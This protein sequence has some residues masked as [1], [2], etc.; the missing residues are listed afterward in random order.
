MTTNFKRILL[1]AGLLFAAA[2]SWSVLEPGRAGFSAVYAQDVAISIDNEASY[3]SKERSAVY[4]PH[5]NHMETYEC[6]DCHHDYQDGENILDE[7]DLDED[8]SAACAACHSKDTSVTLKSAY[9]R[10]CMGCH[11]RLNKQ[12]DA[13]L[14]ITCRDCHPRRSP[15]P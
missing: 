3:H 10:Q 12:E 5:E 1:G 4:F 15:A 8:G 6:L 11:R 2:F 7:D 13:A 9:H 14:P